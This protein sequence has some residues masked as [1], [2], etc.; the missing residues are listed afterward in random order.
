MIRRARTWIVASTAAVLLGMSGPAVAAPPVPVS[1]TTAS[2]IAAPCVTGSFDPATLEQGHY[3]VPAHMTL[4]TT[5]K[6]KFGYA[7]LLYTPD[8]DFPFT[9]R[10]RLLPYAATGSADVIAD[11]QLSSPEPVFG[12]CLLR[13]INTR[14]ACIRIDTSAG[15]A[16]STPIPVGDPLVAKQAYYDEAD[17]PPA[18]DPYCG[19]CVAFR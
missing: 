6:A 18:P 2:W 9:A 10:N 11:V 12:L 15:A 19:T 1:S 4:C 14:V 16:T 5:Y 17:I 3:L 8:W 13:D 7:L